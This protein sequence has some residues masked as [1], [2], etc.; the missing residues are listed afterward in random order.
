MI[1]FPARYSHTR[2][3]AA[4]FIVNLISMVSIILYG[5]FC[6]LSDRK[7]TKGTVG[8]ESSSRLW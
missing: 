8:V 4:L 2:I 7:I 6:W 5:S 1:G 3:T